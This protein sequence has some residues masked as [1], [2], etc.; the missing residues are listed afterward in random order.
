MI[1]GEVKRIKRFNNEELNFYLR[2]KFDNGPSDITVFDDVDFPDLKA[3]ASDISSV[4][5]EC[6]RGIFRSNVVL[7][8][9]LCQANV[10]FELSKTRN[11]IETMKLTWEGWLKNNKIQISTSY[12]RK[13]RSV[14]KLAMDYPGLEYLKMDWTLFL[15]IKL[16]IEQLMKVPEF[17][18]QWKGRQV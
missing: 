12:D 3:A 9:T 7:G 10:L 14:A 17:A 18:A 13:L 16:K 4:S 5:K 1:D 11:K 15:K 8:K 6:D 2:T